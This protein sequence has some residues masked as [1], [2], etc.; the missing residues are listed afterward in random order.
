[1]TSQVES[2]YRQYRSRVFAHLAR[3]LGDFDLAEDALSSAFEA[4]LR[5]W[6]AQGIPHNP[7]AWLISTGRHRGIDQLRRLK[8]FEG[9]PQEPTWC[10]Q[11][12]EAEEIAD[13]Q[14]RL[15]FVCAHPSLSLE[16][17]IA[18][19]LREVCGLSTADVARAFLL[20]FPTLAQRL[21]RAK[22]KIRSAKIP[23]ELPQRSLFGERLQAVLRVIYL[24]YNQGYSQVEEEHNLR[25]EAIR[26]GRLLL[27]L[28]PDPEVS[29]LLALMLLHESRRP[30][31]LK[32]GR[33]TGLADQDRSLW[34]QQLL[35]EGRQLVQRALQ[36]GPARTYAV[37]AAISAVHSEANNWRQ[38]DWLQIIG[39][40]DVLLGIDP[41]PVVRLNRAV[42]VS[43]VR[44]SPAVLQELEQIAAL[45][46]MAG[47]QPL[48]A[49]LGGAYRDCGHIAQAREAYQKAIELLVPGPEQEYLKSNLAGLGQ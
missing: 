35:E 2:I 37:Q 44:G 11:A 34:N 28:L 27:E 29:G 40:Y 15:I 36:S 26:L 39:L 25:A 43:Q 20:P 23:F 32:Q 45:D 22:S 13:D 6:P 24:V 46:S 5:Q 1:M 17:Q 38:T 14:L 31:L 48:Y 19:T 3:L 10:T 4:A 12:P 47:Y 30:A 16:A 33:W 49:A 42:A 9:M 21:V 18:L 7:V 41:S 8:R